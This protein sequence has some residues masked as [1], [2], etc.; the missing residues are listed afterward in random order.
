MSSDYYGKIE[1]ALARQQREEESRQ[2]ARDR[3]AHESCASLRI[4]DLAKILFDTVK[5]SERN[6]IGHVKRTVASLDLRSGIFARVVSALR[7]SGFLGRKLREAAS[8]AF[9]LRRYPW[10]LP[11]ASGRR[12]DLRRPGGG[13]L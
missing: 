12:P 3:A 8:T 2:S 4:A 5:D 7:A 6:L 10:P 13:C 11:Q 1:Q 9:S